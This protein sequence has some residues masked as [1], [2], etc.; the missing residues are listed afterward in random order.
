M[1]ILR[2]NEATA[3]R[4]RVPVYMVDDADGKTP[5][6]GLTFSVSEVQVSKN[7]AAEGNSAGTVT[8]V[9]G[10]LY[11]YE[12]TQGEL[13]TDGF[14]TA[15]VIKTGTA[16]TFVAVAQ[17][18]GV[19]VAADGLDSVSAPTDVTSDAVARASFVGMFRALFNR[20]Y[21]K[22]EQTSTQQK[23]YNDSNTLISTMTVSDD[24][25]TQSKG[26]SA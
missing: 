11:Y 5:E 12:F 8:E 3:A 13:N 24:A 7:G 19:S 10:G 15:R 17:V 23:V 1:L 25:V 22:V 21:D 9:A 2:K 4:R 16:R 6:T 14:I 26:K 18:G 20:F